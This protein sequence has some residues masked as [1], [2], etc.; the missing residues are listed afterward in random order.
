[1]MNDHLFLRPRYSDN[2]LWS[3]YM[4]IWN[5]SGDLRR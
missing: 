2:L 5:F 3:E 4:G 1:M